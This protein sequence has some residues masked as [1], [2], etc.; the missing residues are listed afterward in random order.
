ME[1]GEVISKQVCGINNG[2]WRGKRV[3]HFPGG[4]VT[5]CQNPQITPG[6]S[7]TDAINS[8]LIEG[9]PIHVAYANEVSILQS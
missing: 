3:V 6:I 1:N 2:K 4:N 7:R 9:R 5:S 8:L